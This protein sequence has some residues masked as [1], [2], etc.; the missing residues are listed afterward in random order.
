MGEKGFNIEK[1][2]NLK[3]PGYRNI[4]TSLGVFICVILYTLIG[5][6]NVIFA[7]LSVIICM[8]D[9]TEK[10][11]SEGMARL[12]G[13]IVGAIFGTI[14]VFLN[15]D[16]LFFITEYIVMAI[17]LVIFIHICT[18]FNLK[19]SIAIGA[20]V[21]LVIVLGAN[22]DPIMYSLNRTIDTLVGI[23]LAFLINKYTFAKKSKKLKKHEGEKLNYTEAIKHIQSQN[24]YGMKLDL[25]RIEK[26]LKHLGNPEKNLNFVHIAGTNGKGSTSSFCFHILKE[27]GK[28]IGLF[29]SPYIQRFTERIRINDFEIK[30]EEITRITSEIISIVDNYEESEEKP[31]WFEIVTAIAFV[32]F[33]EQKCDVV[34]L[35]VGLGGN[36]DATNVIPKSLVSIITAIGYDHM[37]V[38]GNT[39]E[40]IAEKKAGIIKPKG[41]VVAYPQAEN[42]IEVFRE[43]AN[44]ENATLTV[45]DEKNIQPV[46]HG[47]DGQTFNYKDMQNISIS[48]LGDHQVYNAITAIEGILQTGLATEEQIREGLKKTVWPGRL[49]LLSKEPLFFLDGA[50]NTQGVESLVRNLKAL[51]P[52]E[53]FTF[54]VGVLNTKEPNEMI[55]LVKELA[56]SFICVTPE[57]DRALK[58]EELAEIITASYSGDD[59]ES[60]ARNE[61]NIFNQTNIEVYAAKSVYEAIGYAKAK[62]KPICAFGSLY[63]IGKVRDYFEK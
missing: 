15:F 60:L 30:E 56:E 23:I 2:K 27:T 6:E 45:I 19:K 33:N 9:D 16:N 12:N 52:N 48:L 32:Y 21:Y 55:K 7:V 8:Q 35:E 62:Q 61:K 11:W 24:T 3:L 57:N 54:I 37:N 53:K 36:L 49:E 40:E 13:T 18:I 14:F 50:H 51:C 47:I 5:R 20:I 29:T 41:K 1:I 63:Y 58:A 31:T 28:K 4:K 26:L 17:G 25:H 43:K 46:T 22:E 10:T 39:L 34:V 59:K 44:K 38:L 42:I